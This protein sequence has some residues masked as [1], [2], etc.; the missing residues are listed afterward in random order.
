MVFEGPPDVVS[1]ARLNDLKRDDRTELRQM[2]EEMR[3]GI[4]Y[5]EKDKHLI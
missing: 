5:E 3:V 4:L 1:Y 2:Q